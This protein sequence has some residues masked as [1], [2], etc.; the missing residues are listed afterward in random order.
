MAA[1]LDCQLCPVAD[2][3][4]WMDLH[5][6]SGLCPVVEPE[7]VAPVDESGEDSASLKHSHLY[8]SDDDGGSKS[9]RTSDAANEDALMPGS[10]MGE[11]ALMP[12]SSMLRSMMTRL[13]RIEGLLNDVAKHAN[14]HHLADQDFRKSMR[15][16]IQE[17]ARRQEHIEDR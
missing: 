14:A 8:S 16:E 3:G 4:A 15:A 5:I 13:E 2:E 1:K 6:K 17:I 12:G 10:S 9:K 7:S 11:N